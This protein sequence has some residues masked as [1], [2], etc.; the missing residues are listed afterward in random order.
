[1]KT[2]G[3]LAITNAKIIPV[4]RGQGVTTAAV[5]PNGGQV[6]VTNVDA[7]TREESTVSNRVGCRI[8]RTSCGTRRGPS[9]PACRQT[10]RFA[11]TPN[12]PVARPPPTEV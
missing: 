5:F 2:K 6:P 7:W 10:R 11:P 12:Y 9:R 3:L 8:R 1:V 4:A